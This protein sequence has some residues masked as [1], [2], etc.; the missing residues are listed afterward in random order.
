MAEK[1]NNIPKKSYAVMQDALF[2]KDGAG[3]YRPREMAKEGM[4]A[5]K[6]HATNLIVVC[7]DS[8]VEDITSLLTKNDIPH[9]KVIKV[10]ESFDFI[11]VGDDNCV[12]AWSWTSALEDIGWKLTHEPEKKPDAQ[13]KADNSLEHFFKQVKKSCNC[14]PS[15]Y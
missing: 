1:K 8:S 9:D 11:I 10:D 12:K 14:I 7:T 13:Q 3:A 2:E 5:L 15:D 6:K 4:T